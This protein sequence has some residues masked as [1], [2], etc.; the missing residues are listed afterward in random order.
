MYPES[1]PPLP[2]TSWRFGNKTESS[3]IAKQLKQ[4]PRLG[5]KTFEQCAGF[6]RINDGNNPLDRTPIHPESY[7]AVNRLFEQLEVPLTAIGS[8]QLSQKLNERDAEQ[9]A[10]A[11]GVGVPTMTDIIDSLNRPGRDPREE[12]PPPIF[13]TDVLKMEDLRPGMELKGTVRNVRHFGA[14]VDI[15]VKDDGLIHISQLSDQYVRHPMDVVSVGDTVTVR[16]LDVDIKKGRISLTMKSSGNESG[17][18]S[19]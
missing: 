8:E 10:A 17:A 18:G 15:G 3:P 13:H 4:V 16:V 2:K 6:L 11:I 1:T 9:L 14:F 7:E 12:M 19:R 5:A